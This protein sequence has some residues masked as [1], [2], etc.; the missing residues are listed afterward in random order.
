MNILKRYTMLTLNNN[1]YT[2]KQK[3]TYMKYK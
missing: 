2:T 3:H 1:T